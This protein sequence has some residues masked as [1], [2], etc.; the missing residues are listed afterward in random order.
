MKLKHVLILSYLSL[1]VGACGTSGAIDNL[2]TDFRPIIGTQTD[3]EV[4]SDKLVDSIIRFND[5]W[6]DACE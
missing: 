4:I 5:K 3:A 6:L 1:V 2:C